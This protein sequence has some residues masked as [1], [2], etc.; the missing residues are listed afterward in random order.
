[1][2]DGS[3]GL[4]GCLALEGRLCIVVVAAL[5]AGCIVQCKGVFTQGHTVH[6]VVRENGDPE[7][8]GQRRNAPQW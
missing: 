7:G 2:K 8:Y 5:L 1:M 4:F 3:A 6:V